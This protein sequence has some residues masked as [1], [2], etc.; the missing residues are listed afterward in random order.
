VEG[1]GVKGKYVGASVSTIG[2]RTYFK[3]DPRIT[4][5]ATAQTLA[6]GIGALLDRP[7]IR[8]KVK[9]PDYRGDQ[10]RGL[11]YDIEK[12]KVGDTV[13]IVDARAPASSA[14]G[15]GSAWGSFVWGQGKWGGSALATPTIWGSFNWGQAVWGSSLGTIFNTVVP[16]CAI[17]YYFHY[18]ELE[19]GF[20][21]PKINRKVFNIEA[22]L[23]DAT[24]VS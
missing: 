19:L 6:D 10:Q 12:F 11:G 23:A 8:A 14:T 18:V 2:K 22:A 5:A 21:A 4:D 3:S 20:R 13:K 17:D 24:L 16:I 7:V 9:I 15:V 1:K